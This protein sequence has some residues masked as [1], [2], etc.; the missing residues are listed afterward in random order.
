MDKATMGTYLE[1]LSV[2]KF[3]I[4]TTTF[5]LKIRPE[6][7]IKN[8]SLHVFCYSDWPG[9]FDK[10]I[11]ITGFIVYLMNLPV[12]WRSK[13]PR[14][15]TLSISKTKYVAISEAVKEIKF[16]YYILREIRI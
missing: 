16:I 12:C 3:V 14:G 2:V 15:V 7:K 5:C 10:R 6:S 9:N 4:D 13:A 11:S 8:W 1:M